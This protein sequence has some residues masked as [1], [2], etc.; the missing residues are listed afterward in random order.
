MRMW[1]H[2]K[3][4]DSDVVV[5]TRVRLARNVVRVPFPPKWSDEAAKQIID[6]VKHALDGT[7]HTF[8]F[9]NLDN[10]PQQ[11]KSVLVEDHIISREMLGGK[12]K[13]LF[14]NDAGT[15]AVMVGEEDHLRIQA[16]APGFALEQAYAAADAMDDALGKKLDYAFDEKFGYLT[17]CPTNVGTGMRASVML[18]LPALAMA[19]NINSLIGQVGKLG[20][21]IRGV[22]G[23]GSASRGDLYQLSNQI[24]L[25]LSEQQTVE[26]VSEIVKQIIKMERDMRTRLYENDKLSFADTVCRAFG[27]LKFAQKISSQE[28]QKLLSYVKLGAEL[29]IIKDTDTLKITKLMIESEPHH[30]ALAEGSDLTPLERDEK[31]AAH[32]RKE[33]G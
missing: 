23:E 7:E 10:A 11:N 14:L 21:T 19:G 29:D 25:G 17:H 24:T 8:S 32:I 22:Y 18:H 16:I 12:N 3:G 15:A 33:L 2:E 30:I 1:Y 13:A 27:T 4:K 9:L 20:L 5:S 28:A 6:S 31:R 26:K